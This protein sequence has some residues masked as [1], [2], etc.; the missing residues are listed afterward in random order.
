MLQRGC[1]G[2]DTSPDSAP[3]TPFGGLFPQFTGLFSSIICAANRKVFRLT[4]TETKLSGSSFE[5]RTSDFGVSFL[6]SHLFFSRGEL[7]RSVRSGR[8]TVSRR[9][10]RV[11][12][13][14]VISVRVP[15]AIPATCRQDVLPVFP[16]SF[17]VRKRSHF[18][19]PFH[20]GNFCPG[21]HHGSSLSEAG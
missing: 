8:D 12:R 19:P 14:G 16:D 9:S 6:T 21:A 13:R 20:Y 18:I 10:F 3:D 2:P 15:P 1:T 4:F 7:K 11:T 17:R 5:F